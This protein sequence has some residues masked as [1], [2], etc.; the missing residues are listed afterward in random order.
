MKRLSLLCTPWLV[1]IV[2]ALMLL[3]ALATQY[4]L[5]WEPCTICVE[6]RAGLAACSLA[7]LALVL[8]RKC[9]RYI[10]M[11]FKLIL[12][13]CA[14][15][16]VYLSATVWLLERHVI[17]TTSCSPFPFY[18]QHFP[19]Q[20]WLPYV[21][22]SAGLCGEGGFALLGVSFTAWTLLATVAYCIMAGLL[23]G[24]AYLKNSKPACPPTSSAQ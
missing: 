11:G 6:I 22:A 24:R 13:A 20:E 14:L 7:G 1:V 16:V 2:P 5:G 8:V 12:M 9:N 15:G 3:M 18:A 23:T 19:L 4:F 21:F 10:V 17:E